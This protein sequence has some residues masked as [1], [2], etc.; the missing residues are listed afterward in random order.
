LDNWPDRFT[1]EIDLATAARIYA[2]AGLAVIPCKRDKSPLTPHGVHDA[3]TDAE[4][5]AAWWSRWPAAGIGCAVPDDMIVL[6]CDPRNGGRPGDLPAWPETTTVY[7]GRGDGGCHL[8]LRRPLGPVQKNKHWPG[9][10]DLKASGYVMLPPSLHPSTGDPYTFGPVDAI[11]DCPAEIEALLRPLAA[12][13]ATRERPRRRRRSR[14][15]TDGPADAYEDS[16]TWADVLHG[17]DI[18][19]GDGEADGSRWKRPGSD[20]STSAS[21]RHGLLFVYSTEAGMPVTEDSDPH[22]LTKFHAHAW[23][24]HGGDRSAAARAQLEGVGR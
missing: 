6:D 11:A 17:W 2:T 5:V 14:F 20:S 8:W 16:H 21:V 3:T 24:E 15:S 18:V 13:P 7:S 23:L 10:W 9:G 12:P 4:T 22:G 19:A 1:A